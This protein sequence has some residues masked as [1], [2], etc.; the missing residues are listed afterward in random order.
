VKLLLPRHALTR[1]VE[2]AVHVDDL[3]V[4]VGIPIPNLPPQVTDTVLVL[5]TRLAAHR[6]G[7]TAVLRALSR[8]ERAPATFAAF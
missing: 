6:H 1:I 4:S 2:F 8:A 3:S 7:P 5:L